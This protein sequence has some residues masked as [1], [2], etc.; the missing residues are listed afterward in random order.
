MW[1]P[2]SV[3]LFIG[4]LGNILRGHAELGVPFGVLL[5]TLLVIVGRHAA[6]RVKR[7][8]RCAR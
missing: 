3:A 1:A 4:C 7:R 6:T 2:V 5:V 8:S